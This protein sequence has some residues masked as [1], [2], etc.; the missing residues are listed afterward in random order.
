MSRL[1]IVLDQVIFEDQGRFTT[2]EPFVRFLEE[3]STALFD[4]VVFCSRVSSVT[5]TAPYV[6]HPDQFEIV[7][8]PWYRDVPELLVR[9]M[10]LLPRIASQLRPAMRSWDF[11]I[12]F[13]V[14]PLTTLTLRMARRRGL[15][16]VFWV[17]GDMMVDLSHRLRGARR[18]AGLAAA[19]ICLAGIPAGTP[20]ISMGRRDY[21]F[22]KR[23]GPVHV[24]FSSK[25]GAGDVVEVPRVYPSSQSGKRLLYV[26]RI[27]PEKGVEVMLEAMALLTSASAERVTLTVVGSDFH[28]SSYGDEIARRVNECRLRSVVRF[29]GHV[30]YG[31]DL[32]RQYDTHDILVLPSFTEGFPQV[33]LEAMA[34]GLPVIATRVGGVPNVIEDGRNGLTIVPG[35]A[36]AL[37][38]AVRRLA[39]DGHLAERLARN[40]LHDVRAYTKERQMASIR[41]FLQSRC[42]DTAV[43]PTGDRES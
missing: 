43:P 18:L 33:V 25:I 30:P 2:D 15:K 7:R 29:V 38:A 35:D 34:R 10:T 42:Q 8:F 41:G 1:G 26:G 22:L 19:R 40:G 37:A 20:V 3:M 28:G 31:P 11:V 17:R 5:H 39:D 27:A 4:R 6:L 24:A 36:V 9:G 32:L 14:H 23:M 12:A 13:G 16:G 21:P